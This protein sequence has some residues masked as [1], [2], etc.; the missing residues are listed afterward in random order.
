MAS[1]EGER[2]LAAILSADVAGYAKLMG[3][4][5]RATVR[6]LTDYRDVFR[7]HIERHHGRVVDTPGDNLMAEFA[8]P[9]EAVEAAAEIQRELARRNRQLAEHRRMDFRIGINLGDVL[10]RD[11]ALFGDGVNIAARLE[12]LAEAGGICISGTVFDQVKTKV[13]LGFDFFGEQEVKNIAEPVRAYRV[14]LEAGGVTAPAAARHW[15]RPAIATAAVLAVVSIAL[16]MW[17]KV[18]PGPET[19]ATDIA[20]TEDPVL[21]LPTGPSIAVLPF[22]N[23]SDDPEQEYFADGITEDI[24][25]ELSRFEGL[26]VIARN[27]TFRFKGQAIDVGEVG[28]ALGVRYVLEG[29]VRRSGE[30]VRITAQLID[31]STGGHLWA[32][33]YD[34]ELTDIFAVQDDVTRQIIAALH[35]ELGEATVTRPG[36]PLTSSHEAYDLFLRGRAYKARRTEET[37]TRAQ[38]LFAQAIALDPAFAAAYAE[39]AHA[40]FLAWYYGW[41]DGDL[42]LDHAAQA[43]K[44]AVAL[45]QSLPLAHDRLAWILAWQDKLGEAIA[46]AR[47][48]IMLD[49]NYASGYTT[50]AIMLG[51]GG[52]T[53]EAIKT[54]DIAMRRDPYS[55][56]AELA[57]GWAHF[58]AH[59]YEQAIAD[60]KASLA[61][62]PDFG[63]AHQYLAATHGSLGNENEARAEA[64]EVLRLTPDF[65]DGILRTPYRDHAVRTRL[66]EGLRKA[67]LDVPERPVKE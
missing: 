49:T 60:Y 48:A 9:V 41:T 62:N 51:L 42:A 17:Q 31:A 3:D 32:E 7:D 8:S 39:L 20:A 10:A 27:S 13:E 52:E 63:A 25:T 59:D 55:F 30:R 28:R 14:A 19:P 38:K 5:E 45:D 67:G 54:A 47:Q 35:E 50:L 1:D 40:R 26:F 4:D 18:G 2:R 57:R 11:G 21:A 29:G 58:V 37:N 16:L 33:R 65:V 22:T 53:D 61:L 23:M 46:A 64:T 66:L 15:K 6:T 56:V 36:R 44:K 34:R 43:A 24:I 12:A